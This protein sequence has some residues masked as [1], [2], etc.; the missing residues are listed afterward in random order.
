M[1]I[2]RYL[3]VCHIQFQAGDFL[4]PFLP[5]AA[6]GERV[7]L[8]WGALGEEKV[9]LIIY[10]VH[11]RYVKIQ[12]RRILCYY[13]GM[14]IRE[15][16]SQKKLTQ[17]QAADLVGISLRAYQNHEYGIASPN[18]Y[19]D[20]II[21]EKL[22]AYE[23]YTEE[24]G[25]YP[26]K[27]LTEIISGVAKSHPEGQIAFLYLFGSYAKGKANEKSDVDLLF[28]GSLKGLDL[29]GFEGEL[30]DA[31]HKKVDLIKIDSIL[32][33]PDFLSEIISTGIKIY[34]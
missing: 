28:D 29:I 4:P 21:R 17:K 34:G 12:F 16:R 33:K 15:L 18:S 10:N 24:K 22:S 3:K 32:K 1:L 13:F 23:P 2:F 5:T 31:L 27:E 30:A 19:L 7:Q 6:N 9:C 14:E 20:K 8:K 25:V 11:I 26:V